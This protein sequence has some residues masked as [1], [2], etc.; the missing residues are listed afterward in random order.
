M[1]YDKSFYI[2]AFFEDFRER[3]SN[4]KKIIDL[5]FKE[6]GVILSLC[7][8]DA[9]ANFRYKQRFGENKKYFKKFVREYCKNVPKIS[10]YT[11]D[12]YIYF[13]CAGIH[14]GRIPIL[15]T[16]HSV[17]SV[18]GILA[19]LEDCFNSIEQACLKNDKW[20]HEL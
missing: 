15:L 16:K 19:I 14:K 12:L 10:T 2:T 4:I 20:P 6:E 18:Q 8:I 5:G 17:F 1:K 9:L 13:R 3:I 11:D 7:Q